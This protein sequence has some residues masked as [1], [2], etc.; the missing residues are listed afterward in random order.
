MERHRA[1]LKEAEGVADPEERKKVM[2]KSAVF[3]SNQKVNFVFLVIKRP[4]CVFWDMQWD[5]YGLVLT[6]FLLYGVILIVFL[7]MS[8][9]FCL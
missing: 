3:A 2:L 1:V 4:P 6:V 9:K 7:Y 5:I 8:T